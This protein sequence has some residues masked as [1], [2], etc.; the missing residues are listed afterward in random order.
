[1]TRCNIYRSDRQAETYL[2]LHDGMEFEE[3][4]EPL[5]ASFG[6]PVL[7]MCLELSPDRKLS[8]VETSSVLKHLEEQGYYLQLPPKLTV[9]EEISRRFS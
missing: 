5:Q 2:Y 9:E 8:R 6:P 7:V 1:M 4:P 3:L